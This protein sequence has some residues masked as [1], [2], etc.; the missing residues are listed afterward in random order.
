MIPLLKKLQP[1]QKKPLVDLEIDDEYDMRIEHLAKHLRPNSLLSKAFT[2]IDMHF[3]TKYS[4]GANRPQTIGRWCR[5]LDMGVAIT[6]HNDVRA[7]RPF[8]KEFP[9]VFFIPGMELGTDDELH[10][11]VYFRSVDDAESFYQDIVATRL[12]PN[13]NL[14]T[15]LTRYELFDLAPRYNAFVSLAHPFLGISS[16]SIR[17]GY[18][19]GSITKNDLSRYDGIEV[20]SSSVTTAA[21][22]KA[23]NLCRELD[24]PF[25]AGSDG[26][27]LKVLGN[28]FISS[29]AEDRESF[30]K[31]LRNREVWASGKVQKKRHAVYA[32]AHITTRSHLRHP[33]STLK[34][35]FKRK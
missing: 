6:D 12:K 14:A 34:H 16:H 29:L 20:L 15:S 3:H 21:N 25:T 24:R 18:A 5:K 33:V 9:D 26:H 35:K 17:K 31:A 2:R 10:N 19:N 28:S 1:E 23:I 30:F 27:S 8:E 13:H 7:C 32:S 22:K 4:D 11:L